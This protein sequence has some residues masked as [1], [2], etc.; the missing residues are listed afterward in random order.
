MSNLQLRPTEEIDLDYVLDAEND[1]ENRQY[2]T[3]IP[4]VMEG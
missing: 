2:I 4:L 1:S 3:H